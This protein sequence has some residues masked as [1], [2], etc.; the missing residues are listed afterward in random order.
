M[1]SFRFSCIMGNRG[2]AIAMVPLPLMDLDEMRQSFHDQFPLAL[3]T[4]RSRKR[5]TT[6]TVLRRRWQRLKLGDHLC[7]Y[8]N[9]TSILLL[10][11]ELIPAVRRLEFIQ[12]KRIV[13]VEV[14][15]VALWTVDFFDIR[16]PLASQGGNHSRAA[17][18]M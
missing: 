10:T 8:R 3:I 13:I 7:R 17:C 5:H 2:I 9:R 16:T 11:F 6:G 1:Q 18:S 12:Y 14:V 4:L 15:K